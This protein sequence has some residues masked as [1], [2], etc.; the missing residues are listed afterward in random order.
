MAKTTFS[1]GHNQS[2]GV[3]QGRNVGERELREGVR[4]QGKYTARRSV[5]LFPTSL[6]SCVY[7]LSGGR[8]DTYFNRKEADGKL[9]RS[10]SV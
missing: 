7:S 9:E 8:V 10:K 2:S 1:N 3:R 6:Q 5:T 4:L